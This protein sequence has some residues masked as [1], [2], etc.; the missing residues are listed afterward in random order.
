MGVGDGGA[1]A[2]DGGIRDGGY[3]E[4]CSDLQKREEGREKQSSL[5][6][7]PLLELSLITTPLTPSGGRQCRG[8]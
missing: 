7:M 4:G 5:P 6:L 3:E 1:G 2:A 8:E